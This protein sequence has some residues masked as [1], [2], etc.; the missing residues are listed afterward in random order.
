MGELCS[1]N[2]IPPGVLVDFWDRIDCQGD[3]DCWP[4]LGAV[5]GGSGYGRVVWRENGRQRS[6]RSHRIA[7]IIIKGDIPPGMVPDHLCEN[8]ACNNPRHLKITTRKDNTLR[9][10]TSV[11]GIHARKTHCVQGHPLSGDNVYPDPN[12]RICKTCHNAAQKRWRE[13]KK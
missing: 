4:W 12:R 10:A 3:D 8:R 9:A 6:V 5:K 2:E 13:G 7:A 1:I 11:A